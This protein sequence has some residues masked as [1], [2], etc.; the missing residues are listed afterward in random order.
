M[1]LLNYRIILPN[2]VSSVKVIATQQAMLKAQEFVSKFSSLI[3]QNV[4]MVS[5]YDEN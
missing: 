3:N 1:I 5:L 2:N 4:L